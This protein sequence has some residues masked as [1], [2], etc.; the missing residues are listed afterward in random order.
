[1]RAQSYGLWAEKI[2]SNDHDGLVWIGDTGYSASTMLEPRY[3][4]S[5]GY[6]LFCVEWLS[7]YESRGRQGQEPPAPMREG[8]KLYD[9]L[10]ATTDAGEQG[11]LLRQIFD[12]AKRELYTIRN[13]LPAKGYGIVRNDFHNVPDMIDGWQY[14]WP[15]PTDPEQYYTTRS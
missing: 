8:L 9:R 10:Q 5:A 14:L 11:A 15:G 13:V 3:Y 1:M 6:N 7:W 4:L 2:D 12:L